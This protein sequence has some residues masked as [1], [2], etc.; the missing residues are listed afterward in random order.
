MNAIPSQ[1]PERAELAR[2]LPPPAYPELPA[3]RHLLMKENL[4]S[5]LREHSPN[6]SRK[7]LVVGLAAPL[8]LATAGAVAVLPGALTG[9]PAVPHAAAYPPAQAPV[10]IANAAYTL[11]IRQGDQVTVTVHRNGA[12]K[13]DGRQLERDLARLGV[14]AQV[15]RK[16]PTC[17]GPRAAILETLATPAGHDGYTFTFRREYLANGS[18][19]AFFPIGPPPKIKI[20]GNGA[21]VTGAGTKGDF[22]TVFQGAKPTCTRLGR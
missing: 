1:E 4:M 9:S 12:T 14:N 17:A 2:L 3:D 15:S 18:L 11:D 8:A 19:V 21:T 13:V 5:H 20:S 7:R 16:L 22:L 6:R 10:H